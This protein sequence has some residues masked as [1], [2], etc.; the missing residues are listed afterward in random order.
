[1]LWSNKLKNTTT[2]E[3]MTPVHMLTL[4]GTAVD[5]M[6]DVRLAAAPP[7]RTCLP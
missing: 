3:Y 1:M 5:Y 7:E 2:R 4:P 6:I